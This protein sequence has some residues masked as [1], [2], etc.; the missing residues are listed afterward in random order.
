M[1]FKFL[2]LIEVNY[3][4]IT[5]GTLKHGL[6]LKYASKVSSGTLALTTPYKWINLNLRVQFGSYITLSVW[7]GTYNVEIS[8]ELVLTQPN[9]SAFSSMTIDIQAMTPNLFM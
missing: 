2:S 3:D 1:I 6:S 9:P 7:Q 8:P 4:L 5:D